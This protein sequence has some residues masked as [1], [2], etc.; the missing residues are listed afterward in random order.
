M[1]MLLATTVY[2]NPLTFL[3]KWGNYPNSKGEVKTGLMGTKSGTLPAIFYYLNEYEKAR[4]RPSA[5]IAHIPG[6][7]MRY[8]FIVETRKGIPKVIWV[9]KQY[10]VLSPEIEI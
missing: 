3:E 5:W 4:N 9:N 2:A 7:E 10:K 8:V 6:D 1:I